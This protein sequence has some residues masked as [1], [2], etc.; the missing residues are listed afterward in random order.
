MNFNKKHL[1]LA[2]FMNF[3]QKNYYK[4]YYENREEFKKCKINLSNLDLNG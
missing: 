4:I 2:G 1:K 3:K